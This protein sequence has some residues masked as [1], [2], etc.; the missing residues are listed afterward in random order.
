MKYFKSI[1]CAVI[2]LAMVMGASV[3]FAETN[4]IKGTLNNEQAIDENNN[5][6][7]QEIGIDD[8]E[9]KN[10]NA[11]STKEDNKQSDEGEKQ[12]EGDNVEISPDNPT[13]L[14]LV[15][16][17]T[18]LVFDDN[19]IKPYVTEDGRTLIPIRKLGEALNATVAWRA[20]DDTVHLF[21]N[22]T[23]VIVKIGSPTLET[24]K[25]EILNK[26]TYTTEKETKAVDEN[27]ANVTPIYKT[28]VINDKEITRTMLPFRAIC[29]AFGANIVW[30]NDKPNLITMTI[31]PYTVSIDDKDAADYIENWNYKPA[32]ILKTGTVKVKV[33]GNFEGAEPTLGD[34]VVV[35]I[36]GKTQTAANGGVCAFAEMKAGTY[37][38][39]ATNVPEGYKAVETTVTIKA[40]EDTTVSVLLEKA[41]EA[42]KDSTKPDNKNTD[43]KKDTTETKDDG[44]KAST[45]DNQSKEDT[46]TKT[47]DTSADKK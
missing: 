3:C 39:T 8:S 40:G 47:G 45:D 6:M 4:E 25:F 15:I 35:T 18:N 5:E 34:G 14:T 31:S 16:N 28:E 42:D 10:A 29:E 44:S 17:G 38:V 30:E 37:T 21:R 24:C 33:A 26:F 7:N 2:C 12:P 23:T 1:I 13:E 43:D 36:D 41:S 20:S 11:D 19:D 9:D 46:T 27:N 32:T 22:G